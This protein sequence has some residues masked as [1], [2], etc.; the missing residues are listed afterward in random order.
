VGK[1]QLRNVKQLV[2]SQPQ[3][4][5][6]EERDEGQGSPTFSFFCIQS[7]PQPMG[8]PQTLSGGS[9]LLS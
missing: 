7:A 9:S 6:D 4:V 8:W 2:T 1:A 5:R 3:S